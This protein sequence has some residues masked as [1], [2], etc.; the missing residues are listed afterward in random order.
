MINQMLFVTYTSI[1]I[2]LAT[3]PFQSIGLPSSEVF[4]DEYEL[5]YKNTTGSKY[6]VQGKVLISSKPRYKIGDTV[7]I[8]IRFQNKGPDHK[9][10]NPFFRPLLRKP[11]R[12]IMYNSQKKYVAEIVEFQISKRN[13]NDMDW[14][15]ITRGCSIG[16]TAVINTSKR[17]TGKRLKPSTYYVQVIYCRAFVLPPPKKH[18]LI[19]LRRVRS[20]VDRNLPDEYKTFAIIDWKFDGTELFRSNII[21]IDL[22]K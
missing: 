16:T 5:Q 14:V 1:K 3:V 20:T 15:Q 11:C 4:R 12:V 9:F 18:S 17:I 7:S 21:K 22:K 10:Y 13:P 2:G 19:M 8:D 6:V